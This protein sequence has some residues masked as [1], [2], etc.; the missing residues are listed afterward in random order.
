MQGLTY[1]KQYFGRVDSE[2]SEFQSFPNDGLLGM[3][4]SSIAMSG[5]P[6]F[7]ENL[8]K[9]GVVSQPYFSL[10]LTRGQTNG[11]EV[12]LHALLTVAV[13]VDLVGSL[14]IALPWVHQ[15]GKNNR[16]GRIRPCCF[17]GM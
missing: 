1:Q 17:N 8:I 4:F 14:L 9:E 10:Y 15:F 2:S 3:A 5:Q 16:T 13:R 6:T 7:F 11:S 12:S